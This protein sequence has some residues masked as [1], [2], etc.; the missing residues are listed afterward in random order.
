M[1]DVDG[2]RLGFVEAADPRANQFTL[3]EAG[4][5]L[6]LLGRTF[7]VPGEWIR[8]ADP[9]RV[10]LSVPARALERPT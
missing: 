8:R 1:Y 4:Y 10:D 5:V 6:G 2:Y 3:V 9:E 7:G